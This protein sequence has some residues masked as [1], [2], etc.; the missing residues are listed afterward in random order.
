MLKKV[1]KTG[2]RNEIQKLK[3]QMYFK[4]KRKNNHKGT[5]PQHGFNEVLLI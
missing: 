5:Y 3:I 2:I 1:I 4:E